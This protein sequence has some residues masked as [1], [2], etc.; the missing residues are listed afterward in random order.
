ECTS[1]SCA[2]GVCC[3]SDCVGSCNSCVMSGAIG[4]C[5]N[6]SASA[7]GNPTCAPYVCGGGATCGT[8]C[9]TDAQ[10]VAG[11]WCSSSTC[12]PKSTNGIACTGNNQCGSGSCTDGVCCNTGCGAACQAC[13]LAGAVGTCSNIPDNTD[14]ATECG[15]YTCNGAGACSTSCAGGS[16]SADCKAQ[17]FCNG[18]AC[19]ADKGNLNGC[20]ADC[21]CIAGTCGTYYLDAD[22][23]GA[24][25]PAVTARF[26]GTAPPT[27]YAAAGND[28]CDSDNRVAPGTTAYYATANNCGN[29][30]YNC[31]GVANLES[32]VVTTCPAAVPLCGLDCAS[33][34]GNIAGWANSVPGCGVAATRRTCSN[35]GCNLATNP[36]IRCISNSTTPTQRCR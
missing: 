6:Y 24:G 9:S 4:T 36:D 34:G 35:I 22:L 25:N 29:F 28:C 1:G 18:S 12:L 26:C 21:E 2:D 13:N 3:T 15:N 7:P 10:C 17:F 8:T 19:A 30:D 32:T 33:F 16:C 5:T 14:P 23:D 27:G 31:N 11:Y 20:T